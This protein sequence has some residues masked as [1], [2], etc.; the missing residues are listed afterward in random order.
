MAPKEIR[1]AEFTFTNG[2]VTT[3]NFSD[4]GPT[5]D[6]KPHTNLDSKSWSFMHED[7]TGRESMIVINLSHVR[8]ARM[9]YAVNEESTS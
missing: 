4:S 8:M 1:V 7:E 5:F 9:F 2:E 6:W 3:F